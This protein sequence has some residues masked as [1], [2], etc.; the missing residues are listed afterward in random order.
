MSYLIIGGLGFI[1]SNFADY[2]L[3]NG[4]E[5]V[6]VDNLE[7][8]NIDFLNPHKYNPNLKI[9]IHDIKLW[10]EIKDEL[11]KSNIDCVIHLA[12]NANI[13]EAIT[14]PSIDFMNGT[15][16]TH[17]VAELVRILQ[18]KKV[19]Y[20]SG[21]GVYGDRGTTLLTENG[22]DLEPISP[23]GA[24]KLAGEALLRSYAYMFDINVFVF[25]FANVVGQNQTHGVGL[26]FLKSLKNN[27]TSLK[28]L[29]DGNQSKQYIHVLDLIDAIMHAVK[30]SKENLVL[31]VGTTSRISVKEIAQM[32]LDLLQIDKSSFEFNYTGGTRGWDGDVPLVNISIDKIQNLGWRPK[33]NSREAMQIALKSIWDQ[34]KNS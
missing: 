9:F 11:V 17:H 29:G 28:I 1:G 19:I 6:I 26:D 22:V 24:S 30:V 2:L 5:V 25:R 12:S 27:R 7:S 33:L 15:L 18:I 4:Q 13:A 16:I 20:A 32:C 21:S 3:N 34:I 10:E 23:Y 31:N 14:N 8:G